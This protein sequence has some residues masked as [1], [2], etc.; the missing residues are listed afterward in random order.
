M[1][2]IDILLYSNDV[3]ICY[4]CVLLVK[5]RGYASLLFCERL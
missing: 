4:R 5:F 1:F 3:F 2:F